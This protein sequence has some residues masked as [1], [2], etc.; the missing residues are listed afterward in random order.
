MKVH[1]TVSNCKKTGRK[2]ESAVFVVAVVAI[3][4]IIVIVLA[5]A[6]MTVIE[7]VEMAVVRRELGVEGMT[8]RYGDHEYGLL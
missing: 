5:V 4:R 2:G 6:L 7:L 8:G 3:L 1:N